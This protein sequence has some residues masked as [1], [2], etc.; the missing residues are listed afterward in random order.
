MP[1]G[2]DEASGD[3]L[4]ILSL[5][6]TGSTTSLSVSTTTASTAALTGGNYR[7]KCDVAV[8]LA[9]ANGTATAVTGDGDIQAN[10]PEYFYVRDGYKVAG[11]TAAGSGTLKMTRM[12]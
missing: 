11:I 12:D 3:R 9:S 1:M 10:T 4:Q 5:P 8:S 2:T 7:F 6:A